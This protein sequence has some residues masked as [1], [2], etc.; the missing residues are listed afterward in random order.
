MTAPTRMFAAAAA[1]FFLCVDSVSA[2]AAAGELIDLTTSKVGYIALFIF[3]LAYAF[4]MAE[5]FTHLR[6]SKP[7]ILVA[8]ILWAM[9]AYV[10]GEHGQSEVAEAALRHNLLEYGEL[11]L[12]LLVAM[13]YINAMEERQVF[14]RLKAW[15]IQR[16]FS[17]RKLFWITGILA[18][19]LSPIADN[20]TTA[21]LM[22]AVVMAVG[23]DNPK[24]VGISCVNI[25]VAANAGGAFSPF[26]DITTLMVWQRGIIEFQTFFVLFV[27]SVVAYVIP[28][29][30]MHFAVPQVSPPPSDEKVVMLRGAVVIMVLFLATIVTAVLY[31]NV[32]HLPPVIGMMTG[33]AYL[34]L[35]AYYLKKTHKVG[36]ARDGDNSHDPENL[37][38]SVGFDVF[39][40]VGRA[41]WDTLLFFY[42]VIL[43][44]GALGLMGYLSWTSHFM[45]E[46]IGA[47]GANILVGVV[48]AIVDNIPVMFAVLS[49]N[50]DMGQGQ[51][52]L[53]T[54]TAGIGGSLLSVGS[55][56]GV[57]LMGQARGKYTFFGHLKWTPAIA[58]GYGASIWCHMWINSSRF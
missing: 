43:C 11:F 53:V 22:C 2:S 10:Y 18:F 35:F 23:A 45:Y 46:E 44:V 29:A 28:A 51:W 26:G 54:L 56:A 9:V 15:L 50:P 25:V 14:D 57:A 7:V 5:E 32:F 4:V 13:T 47:T 20:L 21:L 30:I 55:A 16:G 41:E 17:Y 3:A 1:L 38:E 49:M 58:L 27:P 48:S 42:G 12:F 8:G 6:K 39:K 19:F 31:H 36:D 24:F 40:K 52:L 33:L 34:Q 37:D